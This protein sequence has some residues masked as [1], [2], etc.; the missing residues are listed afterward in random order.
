[1]LTDSITDDFAGNTTTTGRLTPGTGPVDGSLEQEFDS[2]FFALDVVEGQI[3]NISIDGS[4]ISGA[5][6]ARLRNSDGSFI[7]IPVQDGI[8]DTD[9][10]AFQST[11][12]G[13]IFL[14]IQ[15]SSVRSNERGVGDYS[16]TT[17]ISEAD[18][19]GNSIESATA[20]NIG[21]Q[22]EGGVTYFDD[23]DFFAINIVEGQAYNLSFASTDIDADQYIVTIFDESGNVFDSMQASE[24]SQNYMAEYTG[25]AFISIDLFSVVQ[26]RFGATREDDLGSYTLQVNEGDTGLNFTNGSN[27]RNLINGSFNSET[28]FGGDGGDIIF[29]SDGADHIDGGEGDDSLTYFDASEAISLS[30]NGVGSGGAAGDT[31]VNVETVV[32]S[33]FD[34]VIIAGG[35]IDSLIGGD[36][37]DTLSVANGF[38][39]NLI[40]GSGNDILTGANLDDSL[41]GG[42]GEDLIRGLGGDDSLSGDNGNDHI[43]ANSGDDS[44]FGGSG[45]DFISGGAGNDI[46]RGG[47]GNDTIYGGNGDDE[48]FGDSTASDITQGAT[49]DI[50]HGGRGNDII[51]GGAGDDTVFGGADNDTIQGGIGDDNLRGGAGDD[52]IYGELENLES[53][54]SGGTGQTLSDRLIGG[55]GDDRLFGQLGEDTLIGGTGEDLLSGGSQNDRLFGGDGHGGEGNDHLFG[56]TGDDQIFD[57]GGGNDRIFGQGGDDRIEAGLGDDYVVGGDGND[58]INGDRILIN[59]EF[60]N[61]TLIGGN[62]DDALTGRGGDDRLLGGAD[63]DILIG[64]SGRDI[65]NGG[66][67]ADQFIFQ[68]TVRGL[69]DN[70]DVDIIVDFDSSEGDNISINGFGIETFGDLLPLMSDVNGN[71]RIDFGEGNILIIRNTEMGS[72]TASD[73]GLPEAPSFIEG[74]NADDILTGSN[75]DNVFFGG[76][77]DDI[78]NGNGGEYNQAD[79]DGSISDYAIFANDDGSY[80]VSHADGTDTLTDIDGF[81]FGGDAQWYSLQQAIGDGVNEKT[82]HLSGFFITLTHHKSKNKSAP[83]YWLF[84]PDWPRRR[85]RHLCFHNRRNQSHNLRGAAR[86]YGHAPDEPGHLWLMCKYTVPGNQHSDQYCDKV[87][88]RE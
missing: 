61:D 71:V 39:A 33:N 40:G 60:G 23:I 28:I 88:G 18:D 73:F 85:D 77:G 15:G 49:N 55:A 45:D 3:Y 59:S 65:L 30:F 57:E 75:I 47:A 81:W 68:D 34:D 64:G 29:S 48:L 4:G 41:R 9:V 72:L 51:N 82:A 21:Q 70:S 53:L 44:V 66:D 38:A 46:L 87:T 86:T 16:I 31:I 62:G 56:G 37:N 19:G 63:N 76:A 78:I 79:Y 22:L 54:N 11:T 2:D 5:W 20:L 8:A 10:I 32:G 27:V 35:D 43:I 80:T 84:P 13:T 58:I 1:M 25:Q 7:S 17:T 83:D 6:T 14:E 26:G 50:L 52:I 74:T 12:T 42:D 36:G 69:G 67:G 24:L